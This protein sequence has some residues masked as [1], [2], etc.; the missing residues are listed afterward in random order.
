MY[1]GKGLHPIDA[2]AGALMEAIERQTALNARL[3]LVEGSFLELGREHAVLNPQS[4]MER[5]RDDY[6]EER[7]YSWVAG[8]D[9]ISQEAILVPAKLAG[10]LWRDVP[11]PSCFEI[12]TSN[13]LAAGNCREEAICQ[14]LCEL[15]ERDSWT[16]SEIGAHTLPWARHQVIFPG[17]MVDI[18]DDFEFY[19]CVEVEDE[20]ALDLFRAANLDVVLHDITSDLGIPTIFATVADEFLPGFPMVHSGIGAHPDARVA[21]RRAIT[22]AAQSR[23][24]DIQG[25]REDLMPPEVAPTDLNLHTRRVSAINRKMWFLGQSRQKRRLSDLPSAVYDTVDGDL[26]YLCSRLVERGLKQIII[27]DFLPPNAPFAVVRVIVP[28]LESWAINHGRVGQ[29]ALE[30]WKTNA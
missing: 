20:P 24:V 11:H 23:C 8:H 4:V 14:A 1:T 30:F 22:E 9:L 10:Y 25:V 29:R 19:P 5:V 26:C 28:G 18:Q 12:S 6:S 17:S 7:T 15:I 27:V 16:L 13:G 21:V 3:P 2:K